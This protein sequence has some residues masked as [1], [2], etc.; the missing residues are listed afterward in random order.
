METRP[1]RVEAWEG[2]VICGWW[3]TVNGKVRVALSEGEGRHQAD[4]WGRVCEGG[5][6]RP[7]G[8]SR[9]MK[10]DEDRGGSHVPW[11]VEIGAL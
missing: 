4:G 2:G 3:H 1:G 11:A 7:L 9:K 6:G 5:W 10:R 8:N